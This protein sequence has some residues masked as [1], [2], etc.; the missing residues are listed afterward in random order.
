MTFQL[1]IDGEDKSD[2]FRMNTPEITDD[3]GSRNTL[4]LTLLDPAGTYRPQIGDP[5]ALYDNGALIFGGLISD[6]DEHKEDGSDSLKILVNCVDHNQL[7]DRHL[8]AE[9]YEEMTAGAI[10]RAIVAEHLASDGVTVNG[11]QDGPVIKRF[12]CNYIYASDAFTELAD[13]TGFS[14]NIDYSRDMKFFGRETFRAPISLSD[15]SENFRDMHVK[16]SIGR[17]RNRQFLRGGRALTAAR[18]ESWK[19]DGSTRTFTTA[20]PLGAAPSSLK[21]GGTT[22][23]MGIRGVDTGVQWYWSKGSDTVTQDGAETAVP[24]GTVIELTYHGLY[25]IIVRATDDAQIAARSAIEGTSGVYEAIADDSDI[26]DYELAMDRL[27]AYLRQD[28]LIPDVV[29]FETDSQGLFAGQLIDIDVSAHE[30]AGS[31]L[32]DSVCGHDIDGAFMRWTVRALSGE[33]L[34]SWV[35]F[36]RKMAAKAGG[37]LGTEAESEMEVLNLV[38]VLYDTVGT[39]DGLGVTEEV[40]DTRAGYVYVGFCEAM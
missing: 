14:W 25:P 35:D 9:V 31:Y 38:E 22:Q 28:G 15:S 5:I 23:T 3:L 11:V 37:F 24:D 19:G 21:V 2:I 26:D 36:F 39:G 6:S 34:G 17:Y 33:R 4:D 8:V 7:A 13:R 30:L 16:R 18:T 10:V 20:F 12:V 29:T 27:L 1:L 32:I 40:P